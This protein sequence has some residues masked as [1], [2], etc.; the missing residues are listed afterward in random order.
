MTWRCRSN[1]AR[2]SHKKVNTM[3]FDKI[4]N[5]LKME[6]LF[7]AENQNLEAS[8]NAP[9]VVPGFNQKLFQIWGYWSKNRN[10]NREIEYRAATF[11]EKKFFSLVDILSCFSKSARNPSDFSSKLLHDLE[12]TNWNTYFHGLVEDGYLQRASVSDILCTYTL[13]ELKTIAD[14]LGVV[15]KG[16]KS[17]LVKRITPLLSPDQIN[18]ILEKHDLYTVSEKGKNLL[19]GNE[20]YMLYHKYRY[21][22]SL[23][24]FNDN[25]FPDG[26]R[27]RD[28]YDT[29]FQALSNRLFFYESNCNW[30]MACVTH[31]NIYNLLTDEGKKKQ[32]T[33]HYDVILNHYVEFLYLSSCFCQRMIWLVQHKIYPS[34]LE[35]FALPRP[36]E[37][38]YKLAE[39]Q[40]SINYELIFSNK[41]PSIF[42]NDEFMLYVKELLNAPMFDVGKWDRLVQ[43]RVDEILKLIK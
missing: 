43:K 10:Y 17:E 20:D 21:V 16:K 13:N 2:S 42:T 12:I 26:T 6:N 23:A 5:A 11:D 34:L 27:K 28:F 36:D 3:F 22:I 33:K 40:S 32:T 7:P 30:S 24:E 35:S 14:S 38:I 4:L 31:L 25:R 9:I 19:A 41:P 8:T 18:Q 39:F 15:K 29:M 37:N 1:F